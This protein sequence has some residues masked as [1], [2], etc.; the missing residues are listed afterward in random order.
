MERVAVLTDLR[1]PK[2]FFPTDWDSTILVNQTALIRSLLQQDP[3][4]RP[5]A[6]DLLASPLVPPLKSTESAFRKQVLEAFNNPDGNLYRFIVNNLMTVSC[7][8]AAVS[9]IEYALLIFCVRA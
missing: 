7:S 2:I 5:S 9:I 4:R 8:R 1:K 6:S 3:S